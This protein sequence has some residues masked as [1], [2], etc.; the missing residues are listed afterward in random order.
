MRDSNVLLMGT[1]LL[2]P[3]S[4]SSNRR[5]TQRVCNDLLL[6]SETPSSSQKSRNAV[7]NGSRG[8]YRNVLRDLPK[9]ILRRGRNLYYRHVVPADARRL[10]NRLEIWRSLRTDSLS[11]A[12]RGLPSVVARI[13]MEIEQARSIAGLPSDPTLLRPLAYNPREGDGPHGQSLSAQKRQNLP[14]TSS[15]W[16]IVASGSTSLSG[17]SFRRSAP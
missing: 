7:G 13:E 4:K 3:L 6:R 5:S 16:R 11:V 8:C 1:K 2:K 14:A 9:G 10:L 17:V 12:M 15:A